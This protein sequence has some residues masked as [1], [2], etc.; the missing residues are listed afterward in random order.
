MAEC[1]NRVKNSQNNMSAVAAAFLE[2]GRGGRFCMQVW[3]MNAIIAGASG[4]VGRFLLNDL[5]SRDRY[6]R[7]IALV[8]SDLGLSSPK[9]ST[10][11]VD[12][13]ALDST[14]PG[15]AC[16]GADLFCTLGTT[17]KK[18]GSQDAFRRVDHDAVLA[19]AR[20]GLAHGARRFFVVTALGA[21]AA[22]SVF[23]NRVKGEVERDIARLGFA[24]THVFRPSLLLGPREE[25]R[26]GEAI[27]SRISKPLGFLFSGPL[28]KYRPIEAERVAH[29]MGKTAERVSP[30][31]FSVHES[32]E[33]GRLG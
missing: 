25:F 4:L 19:F 17:I 14:A 7:V 9:L 33:I 26:L 10:A 29:A 32:H 11:R 15:D 27:A 6:E 12:F 31:K 28:A 22:S 8:R 16:A 2:S 18:A 5:L 21:D 30:A 13:A 3:I 20:W 24:E 1:R 23:Y